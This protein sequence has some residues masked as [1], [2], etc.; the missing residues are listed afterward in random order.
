MD[1]ATVSRA[2]ADLILRAIWLAENTASGRC[3]RSGR[4]EGLGPCLIRSDDQQL[5]R[6]ISSEMIWWSLACASSSPS[7]DV[8]VGPTRCAV[9][10]AAA[11]WLLPEASALP[12]LALTWI[13]VLPGC[14][15]VEVQVGEQLVH[16]DGAPGGDVGRTAEQVAQVQ[17]VATD[18]ARGA[19]EAVDGVHATTGDGVVGTG[20]TGKTSV[21]SC[22]ACSPA[23]CTTVSTVVI[24][25]ATSTPTA[26]MLPRRRRCRAHRTSRWP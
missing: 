5:P 22:A 24:T 14:D 18:V 12:P 19:V 9:I 17:H 3:F 20:A 21:P 1:G 4:Q 15:R 7:A 10:I 13:T 16:L 8:N 6:C 2:L 23:T 11:A 26:T 25:G